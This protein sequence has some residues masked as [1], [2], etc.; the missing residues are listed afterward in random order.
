MTGDL[1]RALE[2]MRAHT[3]SDGW[4]N[5]SAIDTVLEVLHAD[6]HASAH[7]DGPIDSGFLQQF[8]RSRWQP[9]RKSPVRCVDEPGL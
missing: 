9:R 3:A 8:G 6:E 1:T 5:P 2:D 4:R 7:W